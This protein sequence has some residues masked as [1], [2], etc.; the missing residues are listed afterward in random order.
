MSGEAGA[1]ARRNSD[2]KR[3]APRKKKRGH[4]PFS[5]CALRVVRSTSAYWLAGTSPSSRLSPKYGR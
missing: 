1:L 4:R 3:M 5:A 2:D